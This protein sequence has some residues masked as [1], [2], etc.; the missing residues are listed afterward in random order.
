MRRK[1]VK[2]ALCC[3]LRLGPEQG[4]SRG[5]FE[6]VEHSVQACVSG[7]VKERSIF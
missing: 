4:L 1:L 5:A 2:T 3:K 6:D 7:G